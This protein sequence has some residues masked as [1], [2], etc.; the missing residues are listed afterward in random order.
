MLAF[1]VGLYVINYVDRQI[2]SVLL[3][4]IKRDLGASDTQMGL[5]TGLAF[6]LFYTVAAIPIARLADGG[7]RRDVIVVGV[8]VWSVMTAVCGFARNFVELALARV[9]VGVGEATLNPAAH[10]L[11]SDYFP[12]EK[13]ATALALYNVGGNLGIM[14]GFILGGFIGEALGWRMAFMVVGIP[15]LLAA[16]ATRFVLVEP[17]RGALEGLHVEDDIASTR[18]VL[19]FM[20]RQ[21]TFRHLAFA[22]ALYAFAAYGFTTWGSTFLIRVHHMTLSETGLAMGLVQGIGG[23]LGTYAGGRMSDVLS[24]RDE[25]YA[26]WVAAVGGAMALPFLA[27]FLLWPDRTGA[28][29]GYAVAMVFSVFFVGPSYGLVQSLARIRMRAQAAALLLFAINLI[30]LGIA[31]LVVGVL[32][33]A[34]AARFGE[35]AIRYSLLVTGATS[36]WAVVHSL[37]AARSVRADLAEVRRTSG[38]GAGSR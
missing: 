24:R 38:I 3:E 7:V 1:L 23:G 10:S 13:R 29:M 12:P 37:F 20:L 25:R 4:P 15:G 2:L 36:L 21:R 35:Q 22:S 26:V 31:P 34:L 27:L 18:E 6:A 16:I 5:L 30:G 14:T 11:L 32:N 28:L 33:D 9:G 8:V 17:A 19:A